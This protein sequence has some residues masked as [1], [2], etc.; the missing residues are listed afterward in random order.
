MSSGPVAMTATGG[1][2]DALE[3]RGDALAAADAGRRR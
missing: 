2:L 1:W 3:D